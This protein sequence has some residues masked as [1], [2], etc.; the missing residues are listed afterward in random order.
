MNRKS[1]SNKTKAGRTLFVRLTALCVMAALLLSGGFGCKSENGGAGNG[2]SAPAQPG[3]TAAP[4]GTEGN[5]TFYTSSSFSS[6][7]QP[8]KVNDTFRSS[9]GDFALKLL[10]ECYIDGE[11]STLVSPLSVLT[12]LAMTANGAD[13]ATLAEMLAVLCGGSLSIEE[14]NTQ[15]FNYYESLRS[16]ENASFRSANALWLTDRPGVELKADYVAVVNNTFHAQL[17]RAPLAEPAT[18]DAINDW[19]SKNTDGMIPEVLKYGDVDANTLLVLLNAL[20]FDAVWEAQYDSKYDVDDGTFHGA[21]GDQPVRMLRSKERVYLSGADEVGFVK[22][23]KDRNFAFVAL[24]PDESLSV[25]DYLARLSGA[26]FA[27]LMDNASTR[28]EVRAKLPKFSLD[29]GNS[30]R[31]ILQNLGMKLAFTG[32]ADFSKLCTEDSFI[33]D[34]IHKTHI[35]VDESG[36]RAAAVTAVMMKNEAVMTEDRVRTVVLDRPFVYAIVDTTS[37][38][39]LFIGTVNDI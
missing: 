35:D 4:A 17:A 11:K 10:R 20:C 31:E 27:E 3:A 18:V 19:C 23:Y 13:N 25:S 38:L 5:V 15:L 16:T 8:G 12:A 36:T 7:R 9:Y 14:L 24:L 1:T 21:K 32:D 33:G 2:T 26:R 28:Y 6:T 37:W 34:V 39:P 29:W 30:L 22:Y